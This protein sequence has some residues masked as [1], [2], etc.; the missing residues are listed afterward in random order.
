MWILCVWMKCFSLARQLWQ[1]PDA[2]VIRLK[3][4]LGL[5]A[6]C[7]P[8]VCIFTLIIMTAKWRHRK[9]K[10]IFVH[11]LKQMSC[12]TG[13]LR[14]HG[15]TPRRKV[16]HC[17]AWRPPQASHYTTSSLQTTCFLSATRGDKTWGK[18]AAYRQQPAT[19][20][21]K[22]LARCAFSRQRDGTAI[23]PGDSLIKSPCDERVSEGT[24]FKKEIRK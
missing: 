19:Y 1:G 6:L 21:F 13:L 15:K 20:L 17:R 9:T 14:T 8:E 23:F 22:T 24:P 2:A 3:I 18:R 5:L 10:F 4:I 7:A 16:N 12:K 11:K